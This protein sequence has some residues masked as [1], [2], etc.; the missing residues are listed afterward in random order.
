VRGTGINGIL[1]ECQVDDDFLGFEMMRNVAIII[2]K[3]YRG[4][5]P[6][7]RIHKDGIRMVST[8]SFSQV[9]R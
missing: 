6:L 2:D 3:A 7:G 4:L 9:N 8:Q 1:T 5:S